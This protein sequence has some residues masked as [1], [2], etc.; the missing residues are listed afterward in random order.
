MEDGSTQMAIILLTS[1]ADQGHQLGNIM[2]SYGR[3]LN[4]N[5]DHVG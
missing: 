1:S 4:T 2:P 5:G 3:W